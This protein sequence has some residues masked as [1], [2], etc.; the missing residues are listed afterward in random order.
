[1]RQLKQDWRDLFVSF[2][3]ALD[4]RK[5]FLGL[6][7][8]AV[9]LVAFT[10]FLTILSWGTVDRQNQ[11]E[12]PQVDTRGEDGGTRNFGQLL[13]DGQGP[14]I[15]K[16]YVLTMADL[17]IG[18]P[19]GPQPDDVGAD[20]GT[21]ANEPTGWNPERVILAVLIAMLWWYPVHIW[22]GALCRLSMV[23]IARDER[24]DLKDALRYAKRR[25]RSLYF[26]PLGLIVIWITLFL[27]IAFL[28]LIGA[29]PAVGPV[30]AGV[31]SPLALIAAFFL[32]L[33][34]LGGLFGS[35]LVA[36]A[37]AADSNDS[38]DAVSRS[39]AYVFGR[40]W[41]YIWHMLVLSVYGAVCAVFVVGFT[42]AMLAVVS[43]AAH[44]VMDG[45]GVWQ[46]S[47]VEQF[48]L[49]PFQSTSASVPV[50]EAGEQ[51]L[52]LTSISIANIKEHAGVEWAI[53]AG[54]TGIVVVLTLGLALGF[55]VAFKATGFCVTYLSLRRR[56]DGTDAADIIYEEPRDV[57]TPLTAPKKKKAKPPAKPKVKD[58]PAAKPDAKA[59]EGTPDK[60]DSAAKDRAA[61]AADAKAED[62]SGAKPDAASKAEGK[63]K[64]GAPKSETPQPSPDEETSKAAG[65]KGADKAGSK[66]AASK[67][68]KVDTADE[69]A[70]EKDN[71]AG[72]S[73]PDAK[74]AKPDAKSDGTSA[75]KASGRRRRG[76]AKKKASAK[77]EGA[78]GT[79]EGA[80]DAADGD[81]DS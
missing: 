11:A 22:W 27:C 35:P 19:A 66:S 2:R 64:A 44:W 63:P 81:N 56:V 74:A 47:L 65:Q 46:Y 26:A 70:D 32:V 3:V 18:L 77:R 37:I 17:G 6:A 28:A 21:G 1:M 16:A 49:Q 50:G 67:D 48:L 41:H 4:L 71:A 76:R 36:P 31:L 40:P 5:M 14:L 30:V 9:T 10:L 24:I 58:T 78:G 29:I 54:F 12:Q 38:F 75:S 13:V 72:T 62:K 55:I 59:T 79:D 61:D 42:V 60:P 73:D 39:F 23:E 34:E 7:I 25:S 33:L 45:L 51:T 69:A 68:G 8:L 15:V 20:A 52:T 53:F 43:T 80:G 57:F